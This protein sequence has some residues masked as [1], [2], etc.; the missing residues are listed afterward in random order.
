MREGSYCHRFLSGQGE[1]AGAS[2]LSLALLPFAA[3]YS[4]IMRMRAA[5]YRQGVLQVRELPRP[6]I[7]VGNLTVGGTGKTPLVQWL[8][9][10]LM[11]GGRR[12]V[13]LSRGYGRKGEGETRIVSDGGHLLLGPDD[14]GDE[15]YLLASSI[16]GLQLVVGP[17]RY[18]AGLLAMER[19][20]PD[21]FILDDGFQHLRLRRDLDILLLDALI[22]FANGR[23]LPA[24]FLR[25]SISAGERADLIVLSRCPVGMAPPV[26]YPGKPVCRTSH[27]LAGISLLGG[28]PSRPIADLAGQRVLAFAGIASPERFFASLRESGVDPVAVLAFPDHSP[29]ADA[30]IGAILGTQAE[31]RADCLVTTA[32]DAVK[33]ERHRQAL[34]RCW[35]TQLELSFVDQT[36]L[37]QALEKV[38]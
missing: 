29:Y 3:A 34:H 31:S 13:V 11:A 14:A 21:V 6:V 19:L 38:L 20:Q 36:P 37:L 24:G 2:L 18:R 22:P 30:E 8:A 16:P 28:G 25:E 4:A 27:R 23:T 7:S 9:R 5:A 17:D 26:H 10:H 35:V 12:V 33:L 15:P 32:K 1:V